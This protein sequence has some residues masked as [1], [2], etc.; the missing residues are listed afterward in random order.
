ML[1]DVKIYLF[2]LSDRIFLMIQQ[3]FKNI[4]QKYQLMTNLRGPVQSPA[5]VGCL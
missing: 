2:W 1:S 5:S 3:L 4:L